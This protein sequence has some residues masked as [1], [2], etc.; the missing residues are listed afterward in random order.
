MLTGRY[1]PRGWT[2]CDG[3]LLNIREDDPLFQLIGNSYGGDG[4][5]TYAL[6]NLQPYQGISFYIALYGAFPAPA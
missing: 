2:V 1:A 5:T 4:K 3:R 6:P